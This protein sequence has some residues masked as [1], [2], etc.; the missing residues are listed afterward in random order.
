MH[1]VNFAQLWVDYQK[2]YKAV[3]IELVLVVSLYTGQMLFVSTV[4]IFNI[5]WHALRLVIFCQLQPILSRRFG[6]LNAHDFIQ[7][8]RREMDL[9]LI[10][11]LC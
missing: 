4:Y 11:K 7:D 5:S 9:T 1:T 10:S 2:Q 8:K 3:H 6:R